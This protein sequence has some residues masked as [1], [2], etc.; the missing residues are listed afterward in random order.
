MPGRNWVWLI[1]LNARNEQ[2]RTRPREIIMTAQQYLLSQAKHCRRTAAETG[3]PFVA[4]ELKRL[5]AEFERRADRMR[6]PA[7]DFEAA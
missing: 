3:D 1:E 5:A 6:E 4:E 7:P 2:A